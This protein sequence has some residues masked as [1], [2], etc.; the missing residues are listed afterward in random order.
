MERNMIKKVDDFNIAK[1]TEFQKRFLNINST[2]SVEIEIG[3]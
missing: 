2:L 3:K 1:G